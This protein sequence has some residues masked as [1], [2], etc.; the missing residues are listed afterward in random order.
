MHAVE[1]VGAAVEV[2]VVA[3]CGKAAANETIVVEMNVCDS[4]L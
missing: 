2:V 1:E 4:I 3:A